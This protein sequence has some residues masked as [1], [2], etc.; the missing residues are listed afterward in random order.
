M[1]ELTVMRKEETRRIPFT[2]GQSL[3]DIL[4]TT[5]LRVRSGCRGMGA[6]GL[7]RVRIEEGNV[8]PPTSN[9]R[10]HLSR[11][12]LD[13]GIRLACQIVAES[14]LQIAILSPA[15]ESV[16]RCTPREIERRDG[17]PSRFF[18]LNDLPGRIESPYGVAVDL[19][20]THIHL[21]L[22]DLS[23][24]KWLCSAMPLILKWILAPM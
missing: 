22:Y 9:E 3:R 12:E 7:C 24:G 6:C 13:Q 10:M 21:S 1:P 15:R 14:D 20:T 16:W 17:R 5:D 11:T 4:D 19:G 23:N 8:S 18:P 2:S